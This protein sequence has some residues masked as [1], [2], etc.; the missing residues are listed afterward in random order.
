[1]LINVYLQ[2]QMSKPNRNKAIQLIIKGNLF[3]WM[4]NIIIFALMGLFGF[5]FVPAISSGFFSKV[6]F[7]E[8]GLA[9]LVGG[10]IAFSGSVSSS[11]TKE[12]IRKS[13]ER[14]SI[15]KLRESEKRANKYVIFALILFFESIIISFFGV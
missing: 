3:L 14:W 10:A 15:E 12:Y 13:D 1:M 11:K 6:L 7:V 5:S 8:T 4:V 2:K 9:F